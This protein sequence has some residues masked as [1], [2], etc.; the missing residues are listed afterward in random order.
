MRA[1]PYDKLDT[2]AIAESAFINDLKEILSQNR[3]LAGALS[4]NAHFAEP[5]SS[6]MRAIRELSVQDRLRIYISDRIQDQATWYSQKYLFNRKR[7]QQWFWGSV[8]LHG[9]AIV[10]LLLRVQDHHLKLP[11]EVVA[12]AA[13]GVLTWLQ[14]NKHNELASSYSLTAHEIVLVKGESQSISTEGSLSEYVVSSETAFS[15]EHT[16]WAARKNE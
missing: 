4:T 11:V 5:I 12:V 2:P 9:I 6:T 3:S 8:A 16:Q 1:D 10:M 14:A 15:R 13:S 7:A